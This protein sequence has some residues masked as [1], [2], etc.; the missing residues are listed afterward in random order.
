[1]LPWQTPLWQSVP[2]PQTCPSVHLVA[3]T[4]PQST[5]VS[6]PFRTPSVQDGAAQVPLVQIS[7][8]QSDAD[9]HFFPVPH[10]PGHAPPQ[11][12]SV[13][14]P[15][16][17]PSEQLA[18]WQTLVVQ[19]RVAQSVAR[20]HFFPFTQ[21][22]QLSSGPPQSTSVS[23]G[24]FMKESQVSSPPQPSGNLPQVLSRSLQSTFWH[25]QTPA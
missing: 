10:L 3:H 20:E 17:T 12:T 18:D 13:S 24:S 25:A 14:A 22:A 1:M 6:P 8:W 11:S 19:T 7:L 9:P 15:F 21:R 16:L 4:P 5:A 23:G 2:V